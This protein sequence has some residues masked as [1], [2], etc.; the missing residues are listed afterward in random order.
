MGSDVGRGVHG[1]ENPSKEVLGAKGCS[2]KGEGRVGE[3]HGGEVG[4]HKAKV[5]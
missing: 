4:E 5:L 3:D 1:K 2:G